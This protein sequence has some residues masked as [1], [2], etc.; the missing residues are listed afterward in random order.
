MAK[1][2]DVSAKGL[3]ELRRDLRATDR[4][5]LKEIQKTLKEAAGIAA[6]AASGLAPIR[7]GALSRSYRPFTRGNVAGVGS[8]LPYAPVIEFGGTIRPK[9]SPITI[10]PYEPVQRAVERQRDAIVDHL[11]DGIEAAARRHGWH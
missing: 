7:T 3:A 9:G 2:F 8:T 4:D 6:A 5:A 10:R 11:A 1:D